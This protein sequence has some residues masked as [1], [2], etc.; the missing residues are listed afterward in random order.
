MEKFRI[1]NNEVKK[2]E[3]PKNVKFWDFKKKQRVQL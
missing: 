3:D 1:N 2:N